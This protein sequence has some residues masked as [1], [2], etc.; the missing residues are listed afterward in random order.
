MSFKK[1]LLTK[2]SDMKKLIGLLFLLPL[3]FASCA[4]NKATVKMV[5]ASQ[6]GDCVGVVPQKC[7]LVKKGGDT[8]WTFFYNQIEGFDYEEG[9]EYVLEVKEEKVENVPADASSLKY[10][11][12]KEV[13]KTPT[14]SEGLPESVKKRSEQGYQW[15]GRV[16]EKNDVNIGR[17]AAEGRMSAPVLKVLV[18]SS[19]TNEFE[20]GDTIHCELIVPSTVVPTVGGEYV[21]KAKGM[22]PAHALGIYMLETDVQD[23][24]R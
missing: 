14:A 6:K 19:E 23:L 13:S 5:V 12:V 21:F 2:Y 20:G 9:Y 11:L 17:G 24:T 3:L 10:I 8:N 4:S 18:T 16:L 15:S 7:L 22:H 1:E